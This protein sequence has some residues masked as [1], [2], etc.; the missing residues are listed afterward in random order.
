MSLT[1][2]KADCRFPSFSLQ[3]KKIRKM[4]KKFRKMHKKHLFVQETFLKEAVPCPGRL[5]PKNHYPH[6]SILFLSK[7]VQWRTKPFERMYFP[8]LSCTKIS[9]QGN[10]FIRNALYMPALCAARH[11]KQLSRFYKRL[12]HFERSL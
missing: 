5:F 6:F 4:R 11:N 1:G 9:K 10:K 2:I 12:Y 3:R 7:T 8:I